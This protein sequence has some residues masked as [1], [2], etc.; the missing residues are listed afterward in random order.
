MQLLFLSRH[1]CLDNFASLLGFW[2]SC[3][4]TRVRKVANSSKLLLNKEPA[5]WPSG[6]ALVVAVTFGIKA[7]RIPQH[8]LSVGG[9]CGPS[10]CNHPSAVQRVPSKTSIIAVHLCS[11]HP[12]FKRI[13]LHLINKMNDTSETEMENCHKGCQLSLSQSG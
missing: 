7:V 4:M 6:C 1:A 5:G 12:D 11:K 3:V 13:C 9:R 8:F 2:R 10:H